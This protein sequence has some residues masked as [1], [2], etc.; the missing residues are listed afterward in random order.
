MGLWTVESRELE[1]NR[2]LSDHLT[3]LLFVSGLGVFFL[4]RSSG[5]KR[6]VTGTVLHR[7]SLGV[8][9]YNVIA[10]VLLW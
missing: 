9:T 10:G 6:G 2:G 3:I 7:R 4:L 5:G 1:A 8:D